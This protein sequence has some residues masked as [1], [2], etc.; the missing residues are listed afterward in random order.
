MR[1]RK[2]RNEARSAEG[3][4]SGVAPSLG[5]FSTDRNVPHVNSDVPN[6]RLVDE[7]LLIYPQ[8]QM[9]MLLK[10]HGMLNVMSTVICAVASVDISGLQLSRLIE[11]ILGNFW[12]S[13]D[14]LLGCGRV[15]A[16]DV[17]DVADYS[18]F[19]AEKVDNVRRSTRDA[20]APCSFL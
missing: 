2:S 10:L 13:V 5:G 7:L 16:S 8:Q 18:R 15:P 1:D 14:R 3:V 6:L 11:T 20:P 12:Q 17:I 9:S 19:F 4:G